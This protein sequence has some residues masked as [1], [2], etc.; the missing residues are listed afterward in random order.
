MTVRVESARS[1]CETYGPRSTSFVYSVSKLLMPALRIRLG[2]VTLTVDPLDTPTAAAILAAAPFEARART[3]GEEVYFEAPVAV[4][5][6]PGAREV[7]E[8]GEVAFWTEGEAIAIGYGRTPVSRGDEIRLASPT[9]IW[10]R[11]REDVRSLAGV[12]E[13]DRVVV[14]V[15]EAD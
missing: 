8:P 6:E 7:V 3:W 10:G 9:N 12:R 14:D 5:R 2:D 15:V 11:A 13:G 4:A 1:V